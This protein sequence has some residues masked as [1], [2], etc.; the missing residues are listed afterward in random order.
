MSKR[1][2]K[3][4]NDPYQK[5]LNNSKGELFYEN[6][7]LAKTPEGIIRVRGLYSI[8]N[9]LGL[10]ERKGLVYHDLIEKK[11]DI[12]NGASIPWFAQWL[13]PKE[14]KYNRASSFHDVGYGKGGIEFFINGRWI[15]QRRSREWFD[16]LYSEL[17]ISRDVKEWNRKTQIFVLDY[18]G[19]WRWNKYRKLDKES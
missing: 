4:L 17:M 16:N 9:P 2:Y 19:W 18:C 11:Y 7:L 15:F 3:I 5:H 8:V 12:V 13:I 6:D 14:G 1:K 10:E